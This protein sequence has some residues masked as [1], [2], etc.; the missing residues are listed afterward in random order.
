MSLALYSVAAVEVEMPVAWDADEYNMRN[1]RRGHAVI[2]NH[3]IFN[4]SDYLPREGSKIDVKNL[5]ETF[6]SLGFEVT[7]HDNLEYPE[8]LKVI[9][10]CT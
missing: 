4:S 10:K 5:Q 2:F 7:T 9:S 3:D 6:S 8:I 1:K